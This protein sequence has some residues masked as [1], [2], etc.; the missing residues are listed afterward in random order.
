MRIPRLVLLGVVL[1]TTVATFGVGFAAFTSSAYVNGQGTAGTLGPLTWGTGPTY[2]GFGSAQCSATVGETN[3]PSDTIYLTAGNLAPSS[4]CSYGDDL[5]NAGSLPANVTEQVTSASGTL[6]AVLYYEDPMFDPATLIG[7]GGQVSP[8]YL[9]V[10]A[11]SYV[12]WEGT[13]YLS[14]DAGNAYQGT[15]CAFQITLTGT[16][17]T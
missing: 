17:G 16:A 14:A 3:S 12:P 2:G 10:P 13:I 6:C 7:S 1:A 15:S 11:D 8:N 4:F 9:I 5:Y